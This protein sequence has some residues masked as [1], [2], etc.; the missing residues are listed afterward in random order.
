M[1]KPLTITCFDPRSFVL[2]MILSWQ[3]VLRSTLR[4]FAYDRIKHTESSHKNVIYFMQILGCALKIVIWTSFCE[5][6][7]M[8]G[9]WNMNYTCSICLA[10]NKGHCFIYYI[11]Y[12]TYW[13]MHDAHMRWIHQLHLQSCSERHFSSITPFNL[14]KLQTHIIFTTTHQNKNY[15]NL[16]KLWQNFTI[17]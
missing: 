15:F 14:R 17:A 3:N 8:K 9:Y 10:V 6:Q 16:K 7:T 11:Q 5:Y 1:N 4:P 2:V 13:S 12:M